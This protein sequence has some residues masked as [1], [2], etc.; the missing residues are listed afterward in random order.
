MAR[1]L[2]VCISQAPG[3]RGTPVSG[4]VF[5]ATSSASAA[6]SSAIEMSRTMRVS[7]AMS[8]GDSIRQTASIARLVSVRWS[9]RRNKPAS[10]RRCKVV[11][12]SCSASRPGHS[13]VS[14]CACSR[15]QRLGGVV[16]VDLEVLGLRDAAHL[17]LARVERDLLGPA[18]RLRRGLSALMIQ[19][20]PTSS[21]ASVK[22]PSLTVGGLPLA[23]RTLAPSLLGV[24]AFAGEHHAGVDQLFVELAHLDEHARRSRAAGGL[25][26]SS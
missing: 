11:V 4:Q 18:E 13:P 17:D 19:K 21:L 12:I 1:R 6:S 10:F 5:S 7:P 8:F 14:R 26:S 16:V 22:G 24:Q 9:R 25:I 3:L 2:A 15:S 23:N 20:P